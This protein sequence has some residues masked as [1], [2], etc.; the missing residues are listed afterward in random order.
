MISEAGVDPKVAGLVY[1]AARAPDAG[2]DYGALV[3]KFPTLS[4]SAGLVKPEGF[5]QLS[6]EAFLRDF[7]GDVAP[8]RVRVMYA[9]HGRVSDTLFASRTTVAAW[10]S[11]PA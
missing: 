11:K 2:E 6:D 8:E 1:V 4:A 7:A 5:A 3:A 10:R 9:E